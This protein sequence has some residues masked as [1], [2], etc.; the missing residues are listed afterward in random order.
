MRDAFYEFFSAPL[1]HFIRLEIFSSSSSFRE[2]RDGDT[3]LDEVDEEF[4]E[5]WNISNLWIEVVDR[6]IWD[7]ELTSDLSPW[8]LLEDMQK[9]SLHENHRWELLRSKIHHSTKSLQSIVVTSLEKMKAYEPHEEEG[10]SSKLKEGYRKYEERQIFLSFEDSKIG[11]C[12]KIW[13]EEEEE[14]KSTCSR[15]MAEGYFST[16]PQPARLCWGNR[17]YKWKQQPFW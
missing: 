17:R 12:S 7:L 14:V 2:K 9:Y 10:K 11:I 6:K 15:S 16:T 13:Q 5:F 8:L 3:T 1:Y 4:S